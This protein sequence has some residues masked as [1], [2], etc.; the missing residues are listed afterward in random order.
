VIPF[1]YFEIVDNGDPPFS[2]SDL[3]KCYRQTVETLSDDR[4]SVVAKRLVKVLKEESGDRVLAYETAFFR[5]SDLEYLNG[6]DA[7]L[8]KEHLLS[9]LD[10][11]RDER[12]FD[13]IASIGKFLEKDDLKRAINALMKSFAYSKNQSRRNKARE[14]L[15]EIYYGIPTTLDDVMRKLLDAWIQLLESKGFASEAEATKE[16]RTSIEGFPF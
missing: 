15:M 13:V 14:T 5:A 12:L 6:N 8:V 3:E 7:A 9:R 10:K 4:K 11:E 16:V 1:L 2:L